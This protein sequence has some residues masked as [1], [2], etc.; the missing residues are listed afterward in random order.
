VSVDRGTFFYQRVDVG[1]GNEDFNRTARHGFSNRELIEIA[2]IVVIDRRPEQTAQ[3][4]HSGA[5]RRGG[6]RHLVGLGDD[7]G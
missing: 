6:L 3:I 1:D 4:A 2:G 7:G 5:G